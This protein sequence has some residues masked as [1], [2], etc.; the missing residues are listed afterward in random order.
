MPATHLL[1]RLA[2]TVCG[3]HARHVVFDPLVADLDRE[4]RDTRGAARLVV[5][6]RGA[7]GYLRSIVSCIDLTHAMAVMPRV[8][9]L[10]VLLVFGLAGAAIALQ[11]LHYI[12]IG[13][14]IRFLWL[15]AP[16]NLLQVPSAF[17]HTLGFAMLPA[18]LM[19]TAAGW[20]V[21]R[22]A[23]AVVFAVAVLVIV[24]GWIAPL[25]A[26][27]G[28][29]PAIVKLHERWQRSRTDEIGTYTT[30]AEVIAAAVQRDNPG[31]ARAHDALRRKRDLLAM[32]LALSAIGVALGR[33]RAAA[34]SRPRVTT[35]VVWWLFAWI[36]YRAVGYW[37]DFLLAMI[38][39]SPAWQQW[40][41]PMIFITLSG[42]AIALASA[43]RARYLRFGL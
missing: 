10:V 43:R 36:A 30:T 20:S 23:A 3:P 38:G 15:P 41:A 14:G 34:S 13:A 7:L 12:W 4:W 2:E 25:A 18:M 5:G 28:R 27:H 21:R 16:A 37:G 40:V 26:W 33:A 1:L 35:L 24:D 22:R 39:L 29:P 6:F 31:R 11:P 32:L 42:A 19:A 8:T 9:W 17:A